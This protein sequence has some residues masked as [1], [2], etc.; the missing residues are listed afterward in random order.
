MDINQIASYNRF[1]EKILIVID[2]Y[3]DGSCLNNPGPGGW[4]Y[5]ILFYYSD[6]TVEK[7]VRAE[8]ADKTTTNNQMELLSVINSLIFLLQEKINV[9]IDLYTDSQYVSKG[10]NEW[11]P[12][13]KKN[14]WKNG[15]KKEILNIELWKQ[16]DYL[17]ENVKNIKISYV[18]AHDTNIY[19]NYVDNLARLCAKSQ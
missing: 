13:W 2:V 5:L 19:N 18:K 6:R 12:N 1:N 4:A 10:V 11:L 9:T 17:V 3:T 16:L 8:K 7:L 14:Q 15:K